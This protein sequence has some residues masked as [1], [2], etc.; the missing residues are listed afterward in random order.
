MN[1]PCRKCLLSAYDPDGALQ[2]VREMIGL[3][4]P[5]QR[6]GEE[7]YRRRLAVCESCEALNAGICGKCGCYAEL[8][9]AKKRLGCPH[10][11]HL[12]EISGTAQSCTK[13]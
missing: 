1:K 7:E 13:K 6:V 9:A 2:T 10:E 5:E 12:W 11:R 4:P 8:R 3:I